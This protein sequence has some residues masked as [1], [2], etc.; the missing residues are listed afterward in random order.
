LSKKIISSIFLVFFL[1]V[2]AFM[3]PRTSLADART[4]SWHGQGVFSGTPSYQNFYQKID[5]LT[6]NTT[7]TYS[8]YLKGSGAKVSM[9][10]LDSGNWNLKLASK[11]NLVSAG[12][13]T[14][15]SG[16]V[17]I[18]SRTSVMFNFKEEGNV[19]GTLYFD[20]CF[21]GTGSNNLLVNPG[22]ESG[23]ASWT[24][25]SKITIVNS[26]STPTPTPTATPTPTET[27]APTETP[28]PTETPAPTETPTPTATPTPTETPTATE[29]PT[30]T[31]TAT[32]TPT[33]TPTPTATPP[34]PGNNTHDGSWSIKANLTTS[35]TNKVLIQ[36]AAT[37]PDTT[38]NVT[39]W[40]KGTP[41]TKITLE[42][43][44]VV[45]NEIINKQTFTGNGS[46][47]LV[48][49][50][51]T[52]DSD[53]GTRLRIVDS[54]AGAAGTMYIDDFY[55]GN[56]GSNLLGNASF[57]DGTAWGTSSIGS[58]PTF[59]IVQPDPIPAGIAYVK[60]NKKGIWTFTLDD[61][62]TGGNSNSFRLNNL[63]TEY[64]LHGTLGLIT[65]NYNS[66]SW[67]ILRSY[68]NSGVWDVGNHSRNH[69]MLSDP[70][71][72]L[73]TQI[74]S[75]RS[76]ITSNLTGVKAL[77]FMTPNGRQ[78]EAVVSVI[79]QQ[80]WANR[81]TNY[82]ANS[83]NPKDAGTVPTTGTWYNLNTFSY[84]AA[85]ALSKLK[86]NFDRV[87]N[88]RLWVIDLFHDVISSDNSKEH[89]YFAYVQSKLGEV[90]N[91]TYDEAIQYIRERQNSSLSVLNSTDAQIDL[92]FT[93]SLDPAIFN[94]P[95]T[96]RVQVPAHWTTSK[97]V[98]NGEVLYAVPVM[99]QESGATYIYFNL[100]PNKGNITITQMDDRIAP[101]DVSNPVV[102]SADS[103]LILTWEK[104]ADADLESIRVYNGTQLV[105]AVGANDPQAVTINGLT[106]GQTY[107]YSIRTVDAAG[108][109]SAGIAASGTPVRPASSVLG[110]EFT[111]IPVNGSINSG[112]LFQ[113]GIRVT[114]AVYVT[115]HDV[116]VEYD[117]SRFEI[118]GA[119][120]EQ[121]TV[122]GDTYSQPNSM[123][124]ILASL[125]KE[126]GIN[127]TQQILTLSFKAQAMPGE[128]YLRIVNTVAADV[129]GAKFAAE[130]VILAINVINNAAN[131]EA[132]I[133]QASLLL[134]TAVSGYQ[135]GEYIYDAVSVLQA[136][137]AIAMLARADSD[138]T[139]AELDAAAS[140]LLKA[141]ERFNSLRIM[142]STGDL[143][144]GGVDIGDLGIAAG[145]YGLNK[146]DMTDSE[147][148]SIKNAD[149]NLDGAISDYDLT[150]I[151]KRLRQIQ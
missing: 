93:C 78:N 99:D 142:V 109:E 35:A 7:Y 82:G 73:Q 87:F 150:F 144:G 62:W 64:G 139:Q 84:T 49:V 34:A 108:N 28:T 33:P 31:P 68:I 24:T 127:G 123:R 140:R 122:T 8:F 6:A 48:E 47:Q 124:F 145:L 98:Q 60:D 121:G 57:E 91:A 72:D 44:N 135:T 132:A 4:G 101:A 27:P 15:I 104:P 11:A 112:S 105:A 136:E 133:A 94:Y 80:H 65:G 96:L 42:L 103:Q 46:W 125:G 106:N 149:I 126:N 39:G 75:S 55:L 88:D 120:P 79:R 143:N 67:P 25:N 66:T 146:A 97:I 61:V 111:G 77:G 17:N 20:D 74:N 129:Y 113:M 76:L 116:T 148:S 23:T 50:P 14:L 63:L 92:S 51:F 71:I 137:L 56:D 22:F 147:W 95:L 3:F 117:S 52:S 102:I 16:T 86:S 13:W 69:L 151:S 81:G 128:G 130:P 38:Y 114:N 12:N 54:V 59:N 2:S 119:L 19:A 118:V 100:P 1:S 85:D 30:P 32:P 45:G 138:A 5:N 131:I 90:W 107:A 110:Y 83:L 26:S 41:G 36:T 134:S 21:F 89:G 10:I 18:G 43:Q 40:M 58:R 37:L 115:A 29:T 141:I 70:G 53:G 9:Y